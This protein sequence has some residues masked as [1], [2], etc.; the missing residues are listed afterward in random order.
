MWNKSDI[1]D[2]SALEA[3]QNAAERSD[4]VFITSALTGAGVPEFLDAVSRRLTPDKT[5]S[6]L[7]LGFDEGRARAWL[8]EQGLVRD[9]QQTQE[10]FSLSVSWTARQKKAFSDQFGPKLVSGS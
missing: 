3:L 8:F 10:G 1:L 4:D 6:E 2:P 7:V 5:Q 9:E